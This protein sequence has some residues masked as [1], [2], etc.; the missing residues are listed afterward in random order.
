MLAVPVGERNCAATDRP[1]SST[2]Q[3]MGQDVLL[4]LFRNG[5]FGELEMALRPLL[6][7]HPDSSFYW[8]LYGTMLE[9]MGKDGLGALQRAAKLDPVNVDVSMSLGAALRYRGKLQEAVELFSRVLTLEPNNLSAMFNAGDAWRMLGMFDKAEPILRQVV[10]LQPSFIEA[11][12]SYADVLNELGRHAEAENCCRHAVAMAP[13]FVSAHFCLANILRD[14]GRLVEACDSFLEAIRLDA[15]F[16]PAYDNL[17]CVFQ[18][19]GKLVDAEHFHREAI[20]LAPHAGGAWFNLGRLYDETNRLSDAALAYQK[21]ASLMPESASVAE[22]LAGVLHELGRDKE[23]CSVLDSV[24]ECDPSQVRACLA[25]LIFNLPVAARTLDESVASPGKFASALSACEQSQTMEMLQPLALSVLA[26]TALPFLIAYRPGN[27][28]QSLSRFGDLYSRFVET[29]K[30]SVE[31]MPGE[32]IRLLIVSHHIR[33]HSVWDVV[34]R[35]LLMHL[36]RKRFEVFIYHLGNQEDEETSVAREL[37]D[38]WRDRS[39]VSG[40]EAWLLAAKSDCPAAIFYPELGMASLSYMMAAHRLAP[41]QLVGWGHPITSG[42][43]TIDIY[44]SGDLIEPPDVQSHYR[45]TLVRLPGTGCCTEFLPVRPEPINDLMEVLTQRDGPKFVIAQR[46]IKLDP[47][48]DL[49]FATIAAKVPD[50]SMIMLRDPIAPWA[51]DVAVERLQAEF[52]KQGADPD[53]Q[54]IVLPWLS[55]G[56]FFSLLD[57]CDVFLDCPSFSGYT[58][59]WQALHRGLTVVTLEGSYLRQRLASGLLRRVGLHTTIARTADEYIEMACLTADICRD[60]PRRASLRQA[61]LTAVPH[62]DR[63]LEVVR[64]FETTIIDALNAISMKD[65]LIEESQDAGNSK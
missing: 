43:A 37:A 65:K 25:K 19:M 22:R 50:G 13:T 38:V 30:F 11:A 60:P 58:T 40:P 12:I 23:A 28:L 1:P 32:R 34:L 8:G 35:G 61:V 48:D 2:A 7:R 51:T 57:I 54:L 9:Q 39:T 20:R 15:N 21:A 42:L 5:R 24:L 63:D 46:A 64:A 4:L 29:G 41:L 36:D 44:L 56:R 17:G 45:E 27:H 31:H 59:A 3:V 53:R 10:G 47:S 55:T 14:M 18:E 52:R 26:E 62:A 6:S 33:R 49:L 16:F